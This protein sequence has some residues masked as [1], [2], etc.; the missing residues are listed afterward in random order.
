MTRG[1]FIFVLD[2][3]TYM[4]SEEFNGDMYILVDASSKS[5]IADYHEL[6]DTIISILEKF[7]EQEQ[8]N[9][10]EQ[11]DFALEIIRDF[12]NNR[13]PEENLLVE[14]IE[15]NEEDYYFDFQRE[16]NNG[17]YFRNW[18]SDHL[19]LINIGTE[20]VEIRCKTKNKKGKKIVLKPKTI[21]DVY[22]G[23]YNGTITS[24]TGV[25]PY[26]NEVEVVGF[27]EEG[28]E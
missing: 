21:V 6:N 18:F 10:K 14:Y 27:G 3:N 2:T 7:K 4:I 15:N 25:I 22:Y 13:Y 23:A 20:S 11:V 1:K 24:K 26:N 17:T 19:Y 9:F 12:H 16:A 28:E 8:M 5:I